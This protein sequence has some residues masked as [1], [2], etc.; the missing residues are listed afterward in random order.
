MQ[1][2]PWSPHMWVFILMDAHINSET[3]GLCWS[4]C[5]YQLQLQ[6]FVSVQ[7]DQNL[8]GFSNQNFSKS[9]L[10]FWNLTG[11]ESSFS[12]SCTATYLWETDTLGT[13]PH[14][15]ICLISCDIP[16]LRRRELLRLVDAHLKKIMKVRGS[17]KHSEFHY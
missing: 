3:V 4:L 16:S 17:A 9:I 7:V 12:P 13:A 1:Q 8:S 11:L 15:V 14:T 10:S 2:L 5:H 6:Y